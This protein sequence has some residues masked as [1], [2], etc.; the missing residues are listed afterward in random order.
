[1]VTL[2]L[3]S[4]NLLIFV[5][6]CVHVSIETNQNTKCIINVIPKYETIIKGSIFQCIDKMRNII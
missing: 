1:M 5:F 4:I 2:L 6:K 3:L